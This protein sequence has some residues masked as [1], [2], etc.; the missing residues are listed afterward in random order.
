MLYPQPLPLLSP[1]THLLC[2]WV[3]EW[4]GQEVNVGH[5]GPNLDEAVGPA[6]R[7]VVAPSCPVNITNQYQSR[8]ELSQIHVCCNLSFTSDHTKYLK[9]CFMEFLSPLIID[10]STIFWYNMMVGIPLRCSESSCCFKCFKCD[11]S[12]FISESLTLG[13]H[14]TSIY[15]YIFPF[16][17][18]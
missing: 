15:T 8:I 11:L 2:L 13:F 16:W 14:Q 4:L 17:L 12:D 1:R 7:A 10:L 9:W 18:G 5:T 3:C 6:G